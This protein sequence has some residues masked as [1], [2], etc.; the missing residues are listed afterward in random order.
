MMK[1]MTGYQILAV[2]AAALMCMITG[3]AKAEPAEIFSQRPEAGLSI[4]FIP[5]ESEGKTVYFAPDEEIQQNLVGLIQNVKEIREMTDHTG[6]W[7]DEFMDSMEYNISV[8]YGEYSLELRSEGWMRA[9]YQPADYSKWRE[10]MLRDE[11]VVN[12]VLNLLKERADFELFDIRRIKG[13]VKAELQDGKFYGGTPHEPVVIDD[14]EK[15][16]ALEALL[17]DA[18][19]TFASGCPFG[20]CRLVLT[21][22]A[23][24][25]II[26]IPAADSCPVFYGDGIYFNY[27]PAETRN[28]EDGQG[29]EALFNLLGVSVENYQTVNEAYY[30]R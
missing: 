26:L 23:G 14:E 12:E 1:Q 24:D 29:N 22:E 19:P 2:L 4:G 27:E 28:K 11:A 18:E 9:F 25:E 13:I 17:S 5:T 30:G 8:N 7:P 16:A 6:G 20:L 15:L 10:W 21:T 3:L